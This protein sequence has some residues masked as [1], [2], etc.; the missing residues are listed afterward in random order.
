MSTGNTL[1]VKAWKS[2]IGWQVTLCDPI[3]QVVS[4]AH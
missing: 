4:R 3:W 2:P 1:G